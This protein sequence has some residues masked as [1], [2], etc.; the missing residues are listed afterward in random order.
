MSDENVQSQPPSPSTTPP[1]IEST[2]DDRTMA[3]VCHIGGA[4]GSFLIPL[5]IWLIKKDQSKFV[6]DQGKEVI[7]FHIT[8]L[9]LHIACGLTCCFTYGALN[10]VVWVLGL[11]FGIMGAVAAQKGEV[12]RYPFALRLI[13]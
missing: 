5:I 2:P 10:G 6:D 4:V 12:Y 7:N 11:V 13:K 9:L 1:S 8:L 3:L